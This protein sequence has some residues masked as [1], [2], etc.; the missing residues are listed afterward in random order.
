VEPSLVEPFHVFEGDV[1]DV[2][3]SPPG[4]VVANHFRLVEPVELS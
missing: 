3:E 1:L 2:V 4:S